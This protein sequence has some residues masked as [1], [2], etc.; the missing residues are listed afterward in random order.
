MAPDTALFRSR[1]ND[2]HH[3][4]T[5]PARA[6]TLHALADSGHRRPPVNEGLYCLK[7]DARHLISSSVRVPN[8]V[9]HPAQARRPIKEQHV[10]DQKHPVRMSSE[11]CHGVGFICQIHA[12]KEYIISWSDLRQGGRTMLQ[13][14]TTKGLSHSDSRG[15]RV[16]LTRGMRTGT[17]NLRAHPG[18]VSTS[19]SRRKRT[20]HDVAVT[21]KDH[22]LRWL[23]QSPLKAPPAR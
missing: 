15:L 10:A 20:A 3:R 5:M 6:A 16:S 21:H 14:G 9:I 18:R 22:R 11:P 7:S 19:P 13:Q 12:Y 23:P 17:Q 4:L 8:L 1:L 2:G